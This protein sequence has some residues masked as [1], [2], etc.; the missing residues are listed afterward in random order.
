MLN[1]PTHLPPPLHTHV[2][3][4]HAA[5]QNECSDLQSLTTYDKTA[6]FIK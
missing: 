3:T 2:H 1:V 6:F 5:L 4:H